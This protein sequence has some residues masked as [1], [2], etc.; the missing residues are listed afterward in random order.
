MSKREFYKW[1]SRSILV[2]NPGDKGTWKNTWVLWFG[3]IGT[4]YVLVYADSLE[5]AL[6][7]SAGALA[8][9]G[10][11]GYF[12]EPEMEDG[13]THDCPDATEGFPCTCD[14][15]YTESGYIPSWEWGLAM[16]NPSREDL[17]RF[18]YGDNVIPN[19]LAS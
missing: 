1:C 16:E 14:L 3:A 18:H 9:A 6:E 10:M 7:D 17:I 4:Q 11:M 8:D 2:A 19:R 5:G 13:S 15:T 12:T